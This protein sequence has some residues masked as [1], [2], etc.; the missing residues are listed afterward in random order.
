MRQEA[1]R[2]QPFKVFI[3]DDEPDMAENLKRL[4]QKAG[5]ETVVETES[6][7]ALARIER[8]LPDFLLTDLR[9]PGLNGMA[10]LEQLRDRQWRLPVIMLTAY[11]SA[12]TAAEAMQKGASD[13]LVKSCS[14]VELLRRVEKALTETAT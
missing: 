12:D 4:L 1:M 8:E 5:Y 7:L 13:F 6:M 9:M 3:L 14:S 2:N 10:L 11:A